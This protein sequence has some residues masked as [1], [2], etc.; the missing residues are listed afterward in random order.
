MH[1]HMYVYVHVKCMG[2]GWSAA[3]GECGRLRSGPSTSLQSPQRP[4]WTHRSPGGVRGREWWWWWCLL[5]LAR[6]P[7]IRPQGWRVLPPTPMHRRCWMLT[8]WGESIFCCTSCWFWSTWVTQ[9]L[10]SVSRAPLKKPQRLVCHARF[11]EGPSCS[12][13]FMCAPPGD[14]EFFPSVYKLMFGRL[15]HLFHEVLLSQ[16]RDDSPPWP[17]LH[18]YRRKCHENRLWKIRPEQASNCLGC[19]PGWLYKWG[20]GCS[21]WAW[22]E[23][24]GGLGR[25]PFP[26]G[27]LWEVRWCWIR[28]SSWP[29]LK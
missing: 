3:A 6:R 1:V 16:I 9:S 11:T 20:W 10:I 25:F 18:I 8:I 26:R 15:F 22:G 7:L 14:S 13:S 2:P 27:H 12:V 17:Y 23:W 19:V 24:G 21:G 4:V 29:S 28:A 5:S